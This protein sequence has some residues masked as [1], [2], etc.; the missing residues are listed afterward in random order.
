MATSTLCVKRINNGQSEIWIEDDLKS[1]RVVA[2][3]AIVYTVRTLCSQE[4]SEAF[5]KGFLEGATAIPKTVINKL[6]ID[7]SF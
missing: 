5:H 4:V 2:T 3:N 6:L 7:F 1:L